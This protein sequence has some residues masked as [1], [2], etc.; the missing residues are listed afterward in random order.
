MPKDNIILEYNEHNIL[1]NIFFF[2]KEYRPI[3]KRIA[4]A[5]EKNLKVIRLVVKYLLHDVKLDPLDTE[6]VLK[7]WIVLISY[8]YIKDSAGYECDIPELDQLLDKEF[9]IGDL[10]T[11]KI[12]SNKYFGNIFNVDSKEMNKRINELID[13]LKE[14]ITLDEKKYKRNPSPYTI[15]NMLTKTNYFFND[16]HGY[17]YDFE[18][19]FALYKENISYDRIIA[20]ELMNPEIIRFKIAM[21]EENFHKLKENYYVDGYYNSSLIKLIP[22]IFGFFVYNL[23]KDDNYK[24]DKQFKFISSEMYLFHSRKQS[25][26]KGINIAKFQSYLKSDQVNPSYDDIN[27][28]TECSFYFNDKEYIFSKNG[29]VEK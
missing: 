5:L 15:K 11:T 7:K 8:Y 2:T 10:K 24:L 20:M 6:D 18:N 4:F 22:L 17:K 25:D 19:E 21:D 16:H 12:E 28:I 13:H 26:S 3:I 29:L 9:T 23:I 14:N 1:K 27:N